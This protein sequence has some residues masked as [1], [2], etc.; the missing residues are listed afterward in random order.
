MPFK[1]VFDYSIKPLL[2]SYLIIYIIL[3]GLFV[4]VI[5]RKELKGSGKK[6]DEKLAKGIGISYIIVG[7]LLYLIAKII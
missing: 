7:P 5:D 2:T 4:L 3:V 1:Y 6:K